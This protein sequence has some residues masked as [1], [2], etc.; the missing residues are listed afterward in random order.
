MLVLIKHT[1]IALAVLVFGAVP[2]FG[3]DYEPEPGS[4]LWAELYDPPYTVPTEIPVSNPL[5]KELFNLLRPK[6]EG[7]AGQPILFAG[8]LKAFKN[9]ALFV[10]ET[11]DKGGSSI[12]FPPLGN[13]DTVALWLRTTDGWVLVSFEGG[14]SDVFY[15]IWTAQFGM[16]RALFE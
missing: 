7:R 6:L 8:S 5:R 13:S 9:W 14:H 4:D 10:G 3:Q 1:A 11:Q 15:D 12:A 16:P 2:I